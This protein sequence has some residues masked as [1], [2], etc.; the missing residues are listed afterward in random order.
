MLE[1]LPSRLMDCRT[2]EQAFELLRSFPLIGDF[3][4]Y[5]FLIDLNYSQLL[6]SRTRTSASRAIFRGHLAE[7]SKE[8]N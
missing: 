8:W 6:S 4:G 5:Q 3:L 1:R 2:M 7:L